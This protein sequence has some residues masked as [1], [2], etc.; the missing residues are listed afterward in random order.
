[1]AT[2]LR[3]KRA[4][5][6]SRPNASALFLQL[7]PC[8]RSFH[9]SPRPQFVEQV[10]PVA[11]SII[12]GLHST[13]GLSWAYTL[14]LSA[15]LIRAIFV[16]PLSI[17]SR[18]NLK[19]EAALAPLLNTWQY[20]LRKQVVQEMEAK[21]IVRKATLAQSILLKKT[22]E[23]RNELYKRWDCP[24]WKTYLPLLQ[25][26]V[27]LTAIEAIR[28]MCGQ[29][30]G[31]LGM[32]FRTKID[33][34]AQVLPK[35]DSFATE[36]MLW[37]PD[38]MVSDPQLI[39]PFILS[40]TIYLNITRGS[41]NNPK[42]LP[43]QKGLDRSLKAVALAI[44]PLTLQMPSAMLLYWIASS[45]FAYA[46]ASILEKVIPLKSKAVTSV[47]TNDGQIVGRMVVNFDPAWKASGKPR[48]G[49]IKKE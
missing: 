11:Y 42:I 3:G 46:Q 24:I 32:V 44:G 49:S 17:Y 26:P 29:Q 39:L 28:E 25:L 36:G 4:G 19:K 16:L 47:K 15:F 34:I 22:R 20:P 13:T 35:V 10:I 21:G 5:F 31:L 40:G 1:M 27:W 18:L 12:D 41:S 30:S 37:F 9:A 48:R 7:P 43:W 6:S 38:L 23:K 14:P 2:I 45:S 33:G 8:Y